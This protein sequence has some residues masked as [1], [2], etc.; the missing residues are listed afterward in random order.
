MVLPPAVVAPDRED[1]QRRGGAVDD[2]AHR[3]VHAR[4]DPG[5]PGGDA[6]VQWAG[7]PRRAA[8]DRRAAATQRLETA[9]GRHAQV[10]WGRTGAP[11]GDTRVRVPLV[12]LV[13]GDSRRLD[14]AGP[15]EQP[16]ASRL[17]CQQPAVD[18]CGGLTAAI[19]SD[20]PTPVGL[21]RDGEGRVSAGH[22]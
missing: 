18:G 1:S 9:P 6:M 17:A 13:L 10:A 8:Q 12:V 15:R 22:P 19:R 2:N 21:K 14:G 4:R 3:L 16:V 11:S 5:D 20:Q 7:R